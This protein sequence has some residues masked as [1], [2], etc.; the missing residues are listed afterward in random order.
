MNDSVDYK[1]KYQDLRG[2]FINSMDSAFRMGYEKGANDAKQEQ[3]AMQMQQA[4]QMQA[5]QMQMGQ[6]QG[7][8]GQPGADEQAQM[9]QAQAEQAQGGDASAQPAQGQ[10][11]LDQYIAELEG[12]VNKSDASPA[13]LKKSLEKIKN[14][15]TFAKMNSKFKPMNKSSLSI[16]QQAA[17]NL[18]AASKRELG[19]QEK[20]ISDIMSKWELESSKSTS[21]AMQVLGTEA[22]VKKE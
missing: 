21:E 3:A 10:E 20:I 5:Q 15:Q 12:L 13:D 9:E 19:L 17:A 1:K 8:P 7:Q 18:T 22:L 6:Q 4:Q 2:R 11:E 16:P 14:F